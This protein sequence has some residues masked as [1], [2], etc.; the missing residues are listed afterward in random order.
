MRDDR[1]QAH[2]AYSS[3]AEPCKDAKKAFGHVG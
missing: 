2:D 1:R 3:M